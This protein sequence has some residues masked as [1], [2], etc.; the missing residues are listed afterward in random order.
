MSLVTPVYASRHDAH[1]KH[2]GPQLAFLTLGLSAC[3]RM[4]TTHEAAFFPSFSSCWASLLLI[5]VRVLPPPLLSTL[6]LMAL[7]S[8]PAA[9]ED[10]VDE[11][12][13]LA[14]LMP[15]LLPRLPAMAQ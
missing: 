7:R 2:Q 13:L 15:K 14:A 12:A 10:K 9:E 5:V 3:L 8:P 4:P 6:A 11:V 1:A